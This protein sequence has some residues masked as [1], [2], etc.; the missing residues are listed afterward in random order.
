MREIK[1]ITDKKEW[2]G[3]LSTIQSINYPFF[4]TWNWGEVQR[5]LGFPVTRL[6]LF[7]KNNVIGV[8]GVTDVKAKR[9]HYL[10]LRHGPVL[11]NFERDFDYV[12]DHVKNIAKEKNASFIRIS[13]LIK[14]ENISQEFFKTKGFRYAPIHNMDAEI[15]SVLDITKSESEL[16]Q[17]MRKTHRYLI[18]K[19][20]TYRIEIVK[21]NKKEDVQMFLNLYKS[22]SSQKKFVAHKGIIEEVD[23]LSEDNE[24]LL[25]F[26]KYEGKVISGVLIDF[27]GTIAIYHHAASDSEYRNIPA[28]YLL[29]WEAIK[30]A[31]QRG[32]KFFNL[33]GIAPLDAKKHPWNGFT[34]FKTG[35]G[36][37]RIEFVHAMDLPLGVLYWRT[38]LIDWITKKKKGY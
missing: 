1:E 24:V 21:S 29:L 23:I 32:K 7:E 19:A 31:K 25:I 3:F 22:F 18:K 36:G 14:K 27:V 9:G 17:N 28:N 12:L 4:Q 10:H 26:A 20:S 35:F 16:L 38:Y 5:R 37:E 33:F 11:Q 8:V 15:C 2:E 34:L 6:G 13:P 30:E